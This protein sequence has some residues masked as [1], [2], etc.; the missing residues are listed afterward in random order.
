MGPS[1]GGARG[2]VKPAEWRSPR[3]PVLDSTLQSLARAPLPAA[4]MPVVPALDD[5]ID[6]AA[7]RLHPPQGVHARLGALAGALPAGFALILAVTVSVIVDL[8][9]PRRG[10]ARIGAA[11]QPLLDLRVRMR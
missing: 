10:L 8:K 5:R 1:V 7:S 4:P 11:D 3:G 2:S 6:H 9:R